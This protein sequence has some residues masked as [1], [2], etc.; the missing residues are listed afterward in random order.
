M[1]A[2]P[3]SRRFL[4][5]LRLAIGFACL[6][7]SLAGAQ[8]AHSSPPGDSAVAARVDEY[9]DRLAASGFDGGVLVLR[10]GRKLVER[11]YGFADRVQN[12]RAE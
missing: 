10:N 8:S 4:S 5:A 11:G 7:P 6:L 2:F 1:P 9:F 3:E 12:I